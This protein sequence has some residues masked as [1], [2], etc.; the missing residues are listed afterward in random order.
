MADGLSTEEYAKLAGTLIGME[1]N[2]K[3]KMIT[4]IYTE[5]K[6]RYFVEGIYRDD[7]KD[8]CSLMGVAEEDEFFRGEITKKLKVMKSKPK[9]KRILFS[10]QAQKR[11]YNMKIED[12]RNGNSVAYKCFDLDIN[13]KDIADDIKK[14]LDYGKIESLKRVREI[15]KFVY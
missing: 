11:V 10:E 5:A 9:D 6:S 15:K 13:T 8:V 2:P 3:Q 4:V 14:Q 7:K 1:R 12:I